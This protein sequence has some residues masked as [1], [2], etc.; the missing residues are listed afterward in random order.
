MAKKKTIYKS[1]GIFVQ[2]M[3]EGWIYPDF[4]IYCPKCYIELR[5]T[6]EKMQYCYNCK[7]GVF[8]LTKEEMRESKINRLTNESNE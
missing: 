5:Q 6:F 4:Q 3:D 2:E 1:P 7:D 8:F